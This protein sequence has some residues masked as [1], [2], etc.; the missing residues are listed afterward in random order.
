MRLRVARASL[1][2]TFLALVLTSCGARFGGASVVAGTPASSSASLATAAAG[3][4]AA[5][6]ALPDLAATKRAFVN[7][8]HD[9]LHALA[10]DPRLTRSAVARVLAAMDRLERDFD[11]PAEA[12]VLAGD[13]ADLSTAASAALVELGVDVPSCGR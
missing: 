5:S 12:P 3:L 4:C 2:I 11:V 10:A 8:A 9:A 6:T 1:V 13:F 7:E